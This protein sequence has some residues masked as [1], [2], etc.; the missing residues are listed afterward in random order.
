MPSWAPWSGITASA[1]D[2][3]VTDDV[4]YTLDDDA[5][6]LFSIEA[7]TGI[8]RVA[9]ALDAETATS[10]NITVRATSD[11]GS[12]TT[13]SFTITCHRRGRIRHL[14]HQRRGCGGRPGGRRRGGGHRGRH[15]GQRFD[16]DVTD[17][18]TYSLDD[19]AGG[20]FSIEAGTGIVRVAGALDAET[21]TSH[22][23]TVRATSDDGST[24]TQ[25]FSIT[26]TDVDE[27]D[28]SAISDTDAA[29]DSVAED[30]VVGSVVGV[31][32][33][34][35]DSDVTDDVTYTL[36]DN[37]GGLFSI[38]AGTGIVRVAGALDAETATTHSIT[39][40]ATSDDGSTATQSFSITV[41]DIDE[42]DVGVVTDSDV[43]ANTVA[44]DA[45]VGTVVGV[46]GLASDADVTD[47]VTYSLS[48]DAGGRFAID[49]NTGVVTVNGAL[50]YEANTS[51]SVTILATSDDGS[52]SS[53]SFT[54]NVTDV[55]EGAIGAVSDTD[56]TAD[57]VGEDAIVGT[58]VGVTA[59]ATDPDV[60]D[61]VTY[62][63]DDDAG[64]LFTIDA[65]T[66]IVTVA[67][68]LDAEAATS[69]S[70]T[71]RATSS[72]TSFST[73]TLSI[74]VNDV[75]EFD[76]SALSDSDASA[77]SVAEDAAVGS[78]V[79]VTASAFDSD[80]TDNVT[81][82]LDDDAGGL[83]SIDA[84]TGVIRVA[85]ALDYETATSHSVTVRASS[86]DGSS[87]SR[88]FTI[89]VT[90]LNDSSPVITAGQFLSIAENATAGTSVG[91][92]LAFDADTVGGLQSWAIIA[93]NTGGVFAIDSVTGE[94]TVA[95]P[96][97]LDFASTP[98]YVL[99]LSVADGVHTSAFENLTIQIADVDELPRGSIPEP[100]DDSGDAGD[101]PPPS[102][103]DPSDDEEEDEQTLPLELLQNGQTPVSLVVPERQI[104]QWSSDGATASPVSEQI[105][106]S[107]A[108]AQTDP[109]QGS[110]GI[111][112]F[113]A[114]ARRLGTPE[115]RGESAEGP[116]ARQTVA[117]EAST[118]SGD[119]FWDEPV[120]DTR[121][122]WD[123]I[124][125]ESTF[126]ADELFNETLAVGSA[127]VM[128][129][130][131]SAGYLLWTLRGGCLLASFLS[132]VPA[133]RMMD[134]LP[135]LEDFRSQP[136]GATA[137]DEREDE[138]SLHSL[139]AASR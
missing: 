109:E 31:T 68:A 98:S 85:A 125:S 50:D 137:N 49:A 91:M 67:G 38:E 35:F 13:Q 110:E 138:E 59:N 12:T 103:K 74:S 10:H 130:A 75:D 66:G 87:A 53:Q 99:T 128:V 39:V 22:N 25:S 70:I 7:G 114:V 104:R 17:D 132:S 54:I 83:F 65:N 4:T 94:I 86:T 52:T 118:T 5:G 41:T 122:L 2:T 32:A 112:V 34:A 131:L 123:E 121:L 95:D 1:F 79:G 134:P 16:T 139:L 96:T 115:E 30:A 106:T 51:H 73:T 19:D 58:T 90:D 117:Q 3:D 133:W 76:I 116:T 129:T 20:L 126:G 81:Y 42:F 15:H 113:D 24:T 92:I 61:T 97:L 124:D 21:A 136:F 27:F 93:G 8:V 43:T 9:G 57:A 6:G 82:T 127:T 45:I 119:V 60:G 102:S 84:N 28:I 62:S 72:D 55:N 135:I 120:L 26:V 48:D 11:D 47:S 69:H 108:A 23:I 37:A 89:D 29:A 33:S 78:V 40:R 56:A 46:T 63:L 71:I 88:T 44:E 80:V 111:F 101:E 107:A 18:V 36:D 105:S 100:P 64:G 14:G 77:D